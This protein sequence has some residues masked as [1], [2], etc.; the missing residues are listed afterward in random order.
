VKTRRLLAIVGLAAVAG[1][2]AWT[3]FVDLPRRYGSGVPRAGTPAAP[4]AEG[5]RKIK[6]QLYYVGDDGAS[7]TSVER[8]VPFAE[9]TGE[10][11]KAIL[12]AQLAP[13]EGVVS[14]VPSGTTVRALFVTPHGEAYVDLSKE[15]SAGHAGGSTNELL[16]IYTL[17]DVLTTNLPAVTA[18]QILVDGK[19]I[20]TLAGHVDLRRPLTKNLSWV[21]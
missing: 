3:L 16:T 10:Q 7:L 20:E 9:G 5:T 13:A 11:A 1:A 19:E 14:A 12:G 18:V 6:A 4:P 15:V 21:R 2:L 8:D 17:V